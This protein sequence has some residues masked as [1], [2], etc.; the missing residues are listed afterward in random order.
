MQGVMGKILWVDLSS[1]KIWEER[2]DATLYRDYVGGYGLGVRYLFDRMK[3]GVDPLGPENILGLTTGPLT[4]TMAI[5][6]NRWMAVGKSP[7]TGGWGDANC[8]GTFGPALKACGYDA[9]F[10]MGRSPKPVYLYLTEDHAELRDATRFWGTGLAVEETLKKE[11]G[12]KVEV[13]WIGE[14]GERCQLTAGIMNDEGRSA[15]RSGLGAVMGS[16]RLKAVAALGNKK[17]P[18]ADE[19]S[20]RKYT[21]GLMRQAKEAN[22]PMYQAF[23]NYGTTSTTAASAMSGDSPVKYWQGA[24]VVDFPQA[25]KISDVANDAYKIK[26]TG[27]WHCQISCSS[28]QRVPSGKYATEGEHTHRPEYET[29]AAFGTMTLTDN[30]EALHKVNELCNRYGADTIATGSTVAFAF[31]CFDKGIL[32]PEMT[33]GLVLTWGN[34]EALVALT[35][36]VLKREGKIGELLGDGV[37]KAAEKLGPAAQEIAVHVHGEEVP[38][39]DS[40][41]SPGLA[42]TYQIDATP[43]RHTQGGTG[44]V[45][46]LGVDPLPAPFNVSKWD[47]D[48]KGPAHRFMVNHGH[49]VNIAGVCQFADFL[50]PQEALL[51]ELGYVTGETWDVQRMQ[52]VGERVATLR[53]AFNLREGLNPATFKL[54]KALVD[55]RDLPGGPNKDVVVDVDAERNSYYAAVGWDP[56][57]SKPSVESLKALGLEDVIDD[58]YGVGA[59]G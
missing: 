51:V 13:A 5:T 46:M 45:E 31:A 58:L 43:A 18:V 38:M 50:F 52:T 41:F 15:A 59:A 3:P 1:A 57:T 19:D 39:H 9:V 11:L 6:G 20:L 26:R 56:V 33:D 24:G 7:K 55:G 32:T 25:S 28:F 34:D 8:G 23:T 37:A 12:H 17:I 16:K 22:S 35:E 2:P 54:P 44:G 36:K 40:R 29:A 49:L 21:T 47:F 4:G 14:A 42:L 48:K 30:L 53:H 27:C 10:F